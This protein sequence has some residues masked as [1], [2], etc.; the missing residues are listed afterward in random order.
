MHEE[1]THGNSCVRDEDA[2]T[3]LR[4]AHFR[5][6]GVCGHLLTAGSFAFRCPNPVRQKGMQMKLKIRYENEYQT[7]EL[8]DA[9]A[10]Q[11]WVC[12]SL[13]DGDIP[14]EEKERLL[15]D[16]FDR[17]FNRPDYNSWHKFERHR[18]YSTA[19]PGKDEEEEDMD[20]SEPL[21]EEVADDRIF[22]RDEIERDKREEQEAVFQWVRKMLEKKP[23]W[24]AAFIAVRLNGVSVNDYAASIGVKDPSIVSK[25]L[26]RAEKKLRENYK[27]RQI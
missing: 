18:G 10:E 14:Q 12:L 7:V 17:E 4:H 9:A 15:Q 27:K 19:Q 16:A 24:A 11:L 21:M 3:V 20:T 23:K 2:P 22:C 25:W 8:D 13:E 1:S 26:S 6:I 5:L